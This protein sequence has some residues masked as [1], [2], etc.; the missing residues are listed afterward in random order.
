MSPLPAMPGMLALSMLSMLSVPSALPASP[1]PSP[2]RGRRP[3]ASRSARPARSLATAALCALLL[4]AVPPYHPAAPLAAAG[5]GWSD[6]AATRYWTADRTAA[7]LAP[8]APAGPA[9]AATRAGP[10]R[11]AAGPATARRGRFFAGLPTVGVLFATGRGAR[12]H[13]CTASVVH[14]PHGDVVLT[15]AHCVGGTHRAFVPMYD[16]SGGRVRTPYGVWAVGGT[17]HPAGWT[18]HGPGSDLDVAFLRLRPDAHGRTVEHYTGANRLV[19][20]TS[21]VHRVTVVGYPAAGAH[22]RADRALRCAGPTVRLPG[23]RQMRFAC[24]GFYG[25]TSGAPWLTGIDA[26]TGRGEVIGEIGGENGGGPERDSERVSYSPL[27]GSA[28]LAAY[29]GAART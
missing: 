23:R 13:T 14:S 1:V 19:T 20:T 12:A 17:W 5:G 7:A 4:A 9:V 11:A 18:A 16:G 2:V 27:L 29:R 28:A 6:A 21:Y 24:H 8:T 15:A 25:G 26:R 10:R 22:N 3:A